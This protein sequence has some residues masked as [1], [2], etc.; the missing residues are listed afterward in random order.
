ML[1]FIVRGER[2]HR[3]RHRGRLGGGFWV[4]KSEN[5]S[6]ACASQQ[7]LR[8]DRPCD[9]GRT[10]ERRGGSVAGGCCSSATCG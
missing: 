9:D 5:R 10:I 1:L 2:F 6:A 4:E 3:G 7:H 8:V